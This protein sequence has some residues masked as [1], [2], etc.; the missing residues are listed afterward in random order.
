MIKGEGKVLNKYGKIMVLALKNKLA[1][2]GNDA[3]RR[4]S[5]SIKYDVVGSSIEIDYLETLEAISSGL[6]PRG[7]V[8]GGGT[9]GVDPFTA[10]IMDWMRAK[11]ITPLVN[12]GSLE[13]RMRSSAWLIT[14]AI[15]QRGTIKSESYKG[16]NVLDVISADSKIMNDASGE[17]M[18]LLIENLDI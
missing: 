12:K 13:R 6:N 7:S 16:T 18:D 10:S 17:I 15:R 9:D 3:S 1:S 8:G 2:D 14:R 11:G 4:T 5:N